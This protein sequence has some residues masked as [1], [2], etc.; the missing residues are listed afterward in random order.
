MLKLKAK[1]HIKMDSF[2]SISSVEI[3]ND[4][5]TILLFSVLSVFV[6]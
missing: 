2:K 1:K 5:E 6:A 4:C 3:Q